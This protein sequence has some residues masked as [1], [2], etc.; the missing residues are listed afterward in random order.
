MR[1]TTNRLIQKL[2]EDEMFREKIPCSTFL[3]AC[4]MAALGATVLATAFFA[5]IAV[6]WFALVAIA[7]AIVAHR[8]DVA[9]MVAIHEQVG[10]ELSERALIS[11]A[12]TQRLV[13]VTR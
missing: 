3:V 6:A 9:R 10:Q 13:A 4:V 2:T 5:V 7:K 8:V 11:N 12:A 1:S